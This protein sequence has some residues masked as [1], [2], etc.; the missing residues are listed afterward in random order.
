ME[1]KK[2]KKWIV[3]IIIAIIVLVV[4]ISLFL[5]FEKM[6]FVGK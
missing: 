3:R 2:S 4:A 1:A 5:L 6:Y